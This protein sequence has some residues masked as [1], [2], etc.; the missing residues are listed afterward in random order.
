MLVHGHDAM[1]SMEEVRRLVSANGWALLV[2]GGDQGPLATHLP[3]LL[4][5]EL[6]PG[7]G[8]RDLVLIGHTARADPQSQ[9]LHDG[10]EALLVFQGPHGYISPAWYESGPYV[11]TWNFTA[12][13]VYGVPQLLEEDEGFAVLERTVE[14]FEA[15]RE[16]P[17]RLGTSIDYARRIASGTVPFRLAATRIEAKAK[18]SQDKPPEVQDRVIAALEQPGP[19]HRPQLAQ[20]MRRVLGKRPTMEPTD[21]ASS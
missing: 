13:H 4:D 6:D 21:G 18:L 10:C 2:T 8:A 9:R 7:G 5:P 12:V 3:C 15:A 17:W 16:P 20:E 1:K 14:H 19:Y 11:P